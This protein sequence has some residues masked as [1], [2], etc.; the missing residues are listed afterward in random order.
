MNNFNSNFLVDGWR[1]ALVRLIKSAVCWLSSVETKFDHQVWVLCRL[2]SSEDI[3]GV[4]VLE[5]LHL[6][7]C[8]ACFLHVAVCVGID[9]KSEEDYLVSSLQLV[10]PFCWNLYAAG[11]VSKWQVFIMFFLSLQSN[12]FIRT[13][14]VKTSPKN[15]PFYICVQAKV[16]LY[17][18][19]EYLLSRTLAIRTL[20]YKETTSWSPHMLTSDKMFFI[21]RNSA[22][23]I[24]LFYM[25]PERGL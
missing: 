25:I 7:V 1:A 21:G 2:R 19:L 8:L 14:V 17:D 3:V 5:Q 18:Y 9:C 10:K 22:G 13:L 16:V 24:T 23:E 4:E 12:S 6:H 11:C 15:I 20:A